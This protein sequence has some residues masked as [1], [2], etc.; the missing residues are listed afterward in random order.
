MNAKT[1]SAEQKSE[2]EVAKSAV[3]GLADL[4]LKDAD[5]PKQSSSMA[6]C[7]QQQPLQNYHKTPSTSAA[8]G[9]NNTSQPTESG[10]TNNGD[11]QPDACAV[12]EGRPDYMLS[13]QQIKTI[14]DQHLKEFPSS[15]F[16]V[17]PA[18]HQQ[19][20]NFKPLDYLAATF[21]SA[22][23]AFE[24]AQ[25]Q[26]ESASQEENY[27]RKLQNLYKTMDQRKKHV[28]LLRQSRANSAAN[29]KKQQSSDQSATGTVDA[30]TFSSSAY[31]GGLLQTAPGFTDGDQLNNASN[32]GNQSS[33]PPPNGNPSE[34]AHP[35]K[36][37]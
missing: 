24:S 25:M 23:L 7:D 12:K 20:L 1:D 35:S 30:H 9:L 27:K 37:A 17:R 11:N 5:T 4:Q 14:I 32:N 18:S 2:N 31:G 19:Q 3:V 15:G 21:E 16:S 29:D 34:R 26:N 22:K 13:A 10:S 8:C 28:E 36:K 33:Q 6:S